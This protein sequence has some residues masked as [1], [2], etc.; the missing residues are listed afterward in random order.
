MITPRSRGPGSGTSD[1][2][3]LTLELSAIPAEDPVPC[4]PLMSPKQ[5]QTPWLPVGSSSQAALPETCHPSGAGP[6]MCPAR[7]CQP[8]PSHGI[9]A[10]HKHR[11]ATCYFQ[12]LG[13]LVP[14]TIFLK[15]P[16][17]ELPLA[18]TLCEERLSLNARIHGALARKVDFFAVV[19][20]FSPREGPL[21]VLY[22]Q[23]HL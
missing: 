5:T 3:H 16:P 17:L 22:S 21:T 12:G 7:E 15:A 23:R 13:F 8:G 10:L 11:E 1:G 4:P 6:A 9:P 14:S 20:V 19:V 18:D 2:P